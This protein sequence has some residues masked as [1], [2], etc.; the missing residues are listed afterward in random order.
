MRE[1]ANDENR[2]RESR[3]KMILVGVDAVVP[4]CMRAGAAAALFDLSQEQSA[5]GCARETK[6]ER[7]HEKDRCNA[8]SWL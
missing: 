6:M 7:R 2:Q 1:R 4:T 8:S 5:K 3:V